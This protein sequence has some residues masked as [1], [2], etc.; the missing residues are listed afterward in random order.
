[1][2][3]Y[4]YT[5]SE[6]RA[7]YEAKDFTVKEVLASYIQKIEENQNLN[8]YITLCL[9]QALQ[10]AKKADENFAAGQPRKLEG[11]PIAV[12]DNFCMKGLRT[13]AASKMLENFI[14]HY[15]SSVIDRILNEG[16]IVLGKANMDEFAMGS[17]NE[18]SYFGSVLNPWG[19]DKAIA[20]GGSSGGSAAIVAAGSSVAALGT[21]TGGSVRQPASF[22]GITGMRPT[23]GL[24]SRYG[25]VAFA[26]SLDQA[27]PM[28]RDVADNAL[29]LSVMAGHDP[30]DMTT[31]T[32]EIPDYS[33]IL[34]NPISLKGKSFAYIE[35]CLSASDEAVQRNMQNVFALLR[36][37][38]AIVDPI[39]L[40]LQKYAISAYVLISACEASSNLARYDGVRY[41]H[42]SQ[43]ADKLSNLYN[44]SRSEGFGAEVKRRLCIGTYA[45]SASE[46]E[47][48]YLRVQK[49]RRLIY[50]DFMSV[51][52][53]YDLILT[54]TSPSEPFVLGEI[55]SP[56]AMYA[57]DHMTVMNALVGLP[58]LSIPSGLGAQGLPLGLQIIGNFLSESDI[59]AL[60]H[61]L[62][63]EIAFQSWLKK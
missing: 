37:R 16:V 35:E 17:S 27:G 26:S 15:N 42:R 28:T 45:L 12:K 60:A 9:E 30:K 38:G 58:G 43:N 13:T 34:K 5:Y 22:C 39:S 48:F 57:Q 50:N 40:K 25:I 18:T 53:K 51:F 31:L 49:L 62:E 44:E 41:T 2:M 36:E 8:G 55:Q 3:L 7:G 24:C 21:D 23:Y 10:E 6:L 29:L 33:A 4:K 32:E 54:P 52:A 19:N 46:Y 56:C 59:Y 14:P 47:E 11:M 20:P 63:K 1:M 61:V